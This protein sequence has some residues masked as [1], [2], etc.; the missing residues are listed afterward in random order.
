MHPPDPVDLEPIPPLIDSYSY[1]SQLPESLDEAGWIMGIDEAGRGRESG[2][3]YLRV[4]TE[5][6]SDSCARYVYYRRH[7]QNSPR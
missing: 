2:F 5:R 7:L 1:H 6:P 3:L 4:L